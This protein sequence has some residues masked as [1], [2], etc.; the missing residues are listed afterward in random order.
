MQSHL[1]QLALPQRECK[2]LETKDTLR[3]RDKFQ[4]GKAVEFVFNG[5]TVKAFEGETIATALLGANILST[6]LSID[7]Y[8]R[9]PVC[10]MGSCQECAVRIGGRKML[11]CLT[12]V[13][14]SLEVEI[15][16]LKT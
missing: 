13:A 12:K 5:I 1:P 16:G 6:K 7:G 4:R 14:Q 3:I 2:L 8:P 10:L 11:A 9:G 15:D